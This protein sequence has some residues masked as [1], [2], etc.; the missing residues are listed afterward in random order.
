M[1]ALGATSVRFTPNTRR[2]TLNTPKAEQRLVFDNV[3]FCCAQAQQAR[4]ARRLASARRS[5]SSLLSRRSV[6][7]PRG[8]R[9]GRQYMAT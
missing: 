2:S 7:K 5:D 3:F 8:V 9:P 6:T 1:C 4:A